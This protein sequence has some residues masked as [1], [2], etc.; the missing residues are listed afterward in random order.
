ML[1][2]V[3][4]HIGTAIVAW[5]ITTLIVATRVAKLELQNEMLRGWVDEH[6]GFVDEERGDGD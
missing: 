6:G 3:L 5:G 4:G 1:L 2:L